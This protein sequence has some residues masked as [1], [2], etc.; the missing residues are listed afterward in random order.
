MD[1][2]CMAISVFSHV[3]QYQRSTCPGILIPIESSPVLLWLN[4]YTGIFL[5]SDVYA[6][7]AVVPPFVLVDFQYHSIG[8]RN[9]RQRRRHKHRRPTLIFPGSRAVDS[10]GPGFWSYR[11]HFQYC[12]SLH[13]SLV[14]SA[15]FQ[16][17]SFSLDRQTHV[18]IVRDRNRGTIDKLILWTVGAYSFSLMGMSVEWWCVIETGLVTR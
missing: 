10:F 4:C 3:C 17:V 14:S 15:Y 12:L 9:R 16:Q 11:W 7:Q 8:K 13:S 5:L 1:W 6:I 18:F 2:V